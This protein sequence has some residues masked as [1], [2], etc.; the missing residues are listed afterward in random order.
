MSEPKITLGRTVA[1]HVSGKVWRPAI[2]V[3]VWANEV[4][5]LQVVIDGSND[6]SY[7][8]TAEECARGI[9]WRTSVREGA[10]VHEWSWPE[11][12]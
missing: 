11:R 4:V 5:N 1:Y 10:G 6:S 3:H 12:S 7:G 8:F 9:A 2:I